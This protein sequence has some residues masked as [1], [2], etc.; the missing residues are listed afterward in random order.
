MYIAV[1]TA[2]FIL[3]YFCYPETSRMSMEETALIFDYGSVKDG[4]EKAIAAMAAL[5]EARA[6][7]PRK[8]GLQ[9]E[10]EER[11]GEVEM[12]ELCALSNQNETSRA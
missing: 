6:G 11:K 4:R 3:I 7:E 9:I 8:E 2:Y 10:G 1:D 5:R 12:A